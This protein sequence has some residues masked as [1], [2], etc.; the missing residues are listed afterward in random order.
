MLDYAVEK[1]KFKDGEDSLVNLTKR[2]VQA[3]LKKTGN[4]KDIVLLQ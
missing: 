1:T 3:K 4:E 2:T